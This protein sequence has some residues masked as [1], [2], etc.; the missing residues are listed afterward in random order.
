[1]NKYQEL[2]SRV[3]SVIPNNR[4]G[5][6][7]YLMSPDVPIVRY[8]DGRLV[9]GEKTSFD[10]GY[11]CVEANLYLFEEGR[12]LGHDLRFMKGETPCFPDHYFCMDEDVILDI[13]PF[14]MFM[15]EGHKAVDDLTDV[16]QL[17]EVTNTITNPLGYIYVDGDSYLMQFNPWEGI[18]TVTQDS[19]AVGLSAV[20]VRTNNNVHNHLVIDKEGYKKTVPRDFCG[21]V[22]RDPKGSMS[23]LKMLNEKGLVR[24][25]YI[26]MDLGDYPAREEDERVKMMQM[27]IHSFSY[28]TVAAIHKLAWM[29]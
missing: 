15:G 7:E 16:V 21:Y 8:A 29:I 18:E 19:I 14:Y 5:N 22:D 20:Q 1:M 25:G 13:T 26:S 4:F 24:E 12:K 28:A 6:L 9:H 23:H 2:E 3:R 10:K 17:I 27:M 11:S